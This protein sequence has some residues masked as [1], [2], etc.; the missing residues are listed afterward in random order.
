MPETLTALVTGGARRVGKAIVEELL[1]AGA[2][3]AFTFWQSEAEARA[4]A[5]SYPGRV[6][7]LPCQLA[8]VGQRTQLVHQ[9]E[10]SFSHLDVLVNNAAVFPRIPLEECTVEAFRQVMAVNLEAPLFLSRD[11]APMLRRAEGSVVNIA[12]IYAFLPLR[13]FTAYVISKAALVALTRQL[14]VELAPQVRVNAVAP[15][16]AEFPESYDDTTK[17]RLIQRTLLQRAGSAREIARLVRFLALDASTI[18]GQ[19]ISVDAGRSLNWG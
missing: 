18:T 5:E 11:L 8:D 7:A 4:L 16:I 19:V 13:H 15:G 17:N 14:A 1:A 3:V 2:Q 12:D 9:L 10:Q 6:Y